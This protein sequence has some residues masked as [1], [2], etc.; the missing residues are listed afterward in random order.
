M[1]VSDEKIFCIYC[2]SP[3]IIRT[4]GDHVI[5]KSIGGSFTVLNVCVKCDSLISNRCDSPLAN[6]PEIRAFRIKF[7]LKGQNGNVPHELD[8]ILNQTHSLTNDTEVKV[9]LRKNNNGEIESKLS[10]NIIV[11]QMVD[12]LGNT[13]FEIDLASWRLDPRDAPML[14]KL[15]KSA[16]K[17]AGLLDEEKIQAAIEGITKS[18]ET[19]SHEGRV[20]A[21]V[22]Q[23]PYSHRAGILKIAYEMAWYWLGD[24]W[25]NDEAAIKIR[26]AVLSGDGKADGIEAFSY[27]M[28]DVPDFA[29]NASTLHVVGI[30]FSRNS[31]T[32]NIK[33]FSAIFEG[34]VVSHD[35]SR[36]EIPAT[37]VLLSH[38]LERTFKLVS[39]KSFADT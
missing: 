27:R 9:R 6:Q 33:L 20:E 19:V 28:S 24:S 4:Q 2:F 3:D 17:K 5:P 39:S 35:P 15:L 22:A 31:I 37:D 30:E 29:E 16:F 12:E 8:P 34:V 14:P 26:C 21:S 1:I 11:N 10:P 32:I 36:Y 23:H 7:G 13:G 18:L 25:L 38:A